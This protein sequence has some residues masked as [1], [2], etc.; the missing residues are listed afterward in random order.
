MARGDKLWESLTDADLK[1]I[2][3]NA[4]IGCSNEDIALLAGIPEASFR[5]C[6]KLCAYATKKRASH[7]RQVRLDQEKHSKNTPVGAI[8]LGK[9]VL[10]QTDK[11]QVNHGVNAE[12]ASLL[13]ML[14]GSSKGKLPSDD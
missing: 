1:E 2:G 13:G 12:T 3:D 6:P 11:Q 9:Q 7:R 8:W 14:D 4:R 5:L 10:G